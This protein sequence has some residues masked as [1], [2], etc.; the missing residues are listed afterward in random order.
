M[1]K[2]K[3]KTTSE[4]G[5]VGLANLNGDLIVAVDTETTGLK[6]GFHD[7]IEVAIV[8]LDAEL[9]QMKKAGERLVYAFDVLIK[10]KR[11]HN[12][13]PDAMKVNG[14]RLDDLELHGRD[15]F[16]AAE[17]F[18]AWFQSLGLS[19]GKKLVPLAKNWAFDAGF[20]KDWLGLECF[21]AIFHHRV[22]ELSAVINFWND[23]AEFQGEKPPFPRQALG[24]VAATLEV[25]QERGHRALDDALVTAECYRRLMR[26]YIK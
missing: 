21:N 4:V 9:V 6:S 26:R 24:M 3:F 14:I 16:R 20:I 8:P 2:R 11:P 12:I 25:P 22:R 10:P 1:V 13:D 19:P 18:D 5:N 15:P 17:Q 7:I 23:R